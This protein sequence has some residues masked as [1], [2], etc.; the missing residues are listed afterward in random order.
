MARIPGIAI[1]LAVGAVAVIAAPVLAR[2][3][4]PVAKVALKA[5]VAAADEVLVRIAE[6]TETAEDMM[7]EVRAERTAR[8]T[9]PAAEASDA[10]YA[11]QSEAPQSAEGAAG[12]A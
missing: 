8:R 12:V 4:R 1:G 6:F 7:A 3:M 5:A 10:D 11:A 9:E 2:H